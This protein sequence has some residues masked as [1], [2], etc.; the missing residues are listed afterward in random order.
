MHS[1]NSSG[2]AWLSSK[3]CKHGLSWQL[4]IFTVL[5]LTTYCGFCAFRKLCIFSLWHA[6]V[7]SYCICLNNG[8][9]QRLSRW[10]DINGISFIRRCPF[11]DIS[12][13]VV[14]LQVWQ[15]CTLSNFNQQSK[16][17][18]SACQTPVVHISLEKTDIVVS[19]LILKCLY[20]FPVFKEFIKMRGTLQKS[21]IK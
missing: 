16:S 4:A 18:I 17:S 10:Q 7:S 14:L 15:K 9:T 19:N 11:W 8:S 21:G 12:D 3:L 20:A 2:A 1:W 13:K 5:S 6:V